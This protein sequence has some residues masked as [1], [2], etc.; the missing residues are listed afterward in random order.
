MWAGGHQRLIKVTPEGLNPSLD[1][2]T[3]LCTTS[4]GTSAPA[5]FM[6]DPKTPQFKP[7]SELPR[8]IC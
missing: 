7:F 1:H 5:V 4:D 3:H 8:A 6:L 2:V